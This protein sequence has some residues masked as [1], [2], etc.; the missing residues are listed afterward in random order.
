MKL[1]TVYT[2]K[3]QKSGKRIR[4][5]SCAGVAGV[6]GGRSVRLHSLP[7]L[8]YMRTRSSAPALAQQLQRCN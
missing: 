7:A 3:I 6:T 2:F 8:P 4:M 1:V 5:I